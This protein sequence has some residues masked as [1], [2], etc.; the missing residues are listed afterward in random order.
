MDE[1]A[2]TRPAR[3]NSVRIYASGWNYQSMVSEVY[4]V[5]E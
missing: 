1:L 3:I 4:L 5:A 2:N